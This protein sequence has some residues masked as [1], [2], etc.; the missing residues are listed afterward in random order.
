[1]KVALRNCNL[2]WRLPWLQRF[3]TLHTSGYDSISIFL[4]GYSGR[5]KFKVS[6]DEFLKNVVI[7]RDIIFLV[8]VSMKEGKVPISVFL[9]N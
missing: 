5:V 7:Q 3:L 8:D 4:I 9:L 1:M 6:V 2:S